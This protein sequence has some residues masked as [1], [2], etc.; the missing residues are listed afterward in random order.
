MI[1]GQKSKAQTWWLCADRQFLNMKDCICISVDW[2]DKW[3]NGKKRWK[4]CQIKT[5]TLDDNI[6]AEILFV[7]Y[8]TSESNT[9]FCR[10]NHKS[11]SSFLRCRKV[12]GSKMKGKMEG[13]QQSQR[14]HFYPAELNW[15]WL[16]TKPWEG[17]ENT[18]TPA[19]NPHAP[20]QQKQI[21]I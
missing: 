14:K 21:N 4:K 18:P 13:K 12:R 19:H 2:S 5:V 16:W 9:S 7:V 10:N 20:M 15:V 8:K 17:W 3:D 6:S 1:M 11:L